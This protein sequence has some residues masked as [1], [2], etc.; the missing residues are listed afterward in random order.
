MNKQNTKQQLRRSLFALAVVGALTVGAAL[1][2]PKADAGKPS[3]KPYGPGALYQ[4]E[5]VSGDNG[6]SYAPVGQRGKAAALNGGGQWL[7][8]ALYPDGTADYAGSDCLS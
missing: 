2:L 6:A 7:W 1:T 8:F 3:D 4:I 5:F